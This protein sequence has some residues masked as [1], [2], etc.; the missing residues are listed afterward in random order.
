MAL[1]PSTTNYEEIQ[2]NEIKALQSIYMEDFMEEEAKAGAWKVGPTSRSGRS[3]DAI[4]IFVY[5]QGCKVA[6]YFIFLLLAF[7][8]CALYTR[9]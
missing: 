5:S 1:K 8:L 4:Y 6:S 3:F 7:L 9:H 2:Q